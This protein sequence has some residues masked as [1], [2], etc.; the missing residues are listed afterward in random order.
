MTVF[1]VIG[2]GAKKYGGFERYIVEEALQLKEKKCQLVV[3][4]DRTP[5]AKDYI[6][7]LEALGSAIEVLPQNSKV[8]FAKGFITLLKKY[9]PSIVHTNFSSNLFVALPLARLYGVKKRIASEHCLPVIESLK[10]RISAQLIALFAN[11]VLPVSQKSC[12]TL[13]NGIIFNKNRI[14]TLYLGIPEFSYNKTEM[15]NRIGIDDSTFALMNIAYHH[16]VK[17]VDILL[18]ALSILV[19][20]KGHNDIVLYQIG[21]SHTDGDT[22]KLKQLAENLNLENNIVWMGL[23][24]DVPMLLAAGDLYVQPSRSEGIP[25]SI[26]EANMAKLPIVATNVGGNPEAAVDEI[27]AILIPPENPNG[28]ADGIERLYLDSMLRKQ[29]GDKGH[30]L[31]LDNFSIQRQVSRL[32]TD[33]YGL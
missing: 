1:E 14:K 12:D 31:A 16:P 13:V 32:I 28:L 5:L 4:F 25:L 3:I 21:G 33:Y 27:N 30:K 11:K 29:Y 19:K 23:R 10:S 18:R 26:M 17:G 9:K 8:H 22:A 24:N 15:R 7:D 6:K 2:M 20:D